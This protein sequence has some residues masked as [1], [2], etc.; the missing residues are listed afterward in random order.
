[1]SITT[2]NEAQIILRVAKELRVGRLKLAAF[3]GGSKAKEVSALVQHP[4]YGGVIW[5]TQ[6]EILSFLKQLEELKLIREIRVSTT[7]YSYPVLEITPDGGRAF[8]EHRS[9]PLKRQLL[10][11]PISASEEE[12]YALFEQGKSPQQIADARQLQLSTVYEHFIV[13]IGNG[14]FSAQRVVN[15]AIIKEVLEAKKRLGPHARLK[16]IKDQLPEVSY[17]EMRCVL[18]D[19]RLRQ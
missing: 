7:D 4:G 5:C 2:D 1:M 10:Q 14:R 13:L 8:V 6:D 12:T 15:S 11:K 18:A 19:E 9:I 16:E 17:V 3:L